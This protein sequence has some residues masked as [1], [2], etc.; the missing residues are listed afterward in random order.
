MPAK[1]AYAIVNSGTTTS[2]GLEGG[3]TS[4]PSSNF[5]LTEHKAGDF[6]RTVMWKGSSRK[7]NGGRETC[8]KDIFKKESELKGTTRGIDSWTEDPI[9]GGQAY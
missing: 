2:K 7:E 5:D 4:F 8:E 6:A 3:P 9:T 1:V